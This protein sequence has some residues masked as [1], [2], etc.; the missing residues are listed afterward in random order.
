QR[1]RGRGA[2]EHDPDPAR[3]RDQLQGD[4]D[5][6]PDAAASDP[7]LG[8]RLMR[9]CRAFA[10]LALAVVVLAGCNTLP[11]TEVQQ[12]MTA[13]PAPVPQPAAQPASGSIYAAAN[14]G[15]PYFGYRPLFEDRRPRNVGDI[16]V[17]QINEKTAASKQSDSSVEKS[18]ST[19]F[20]V[21][22]LLGLPGKSFQGANLEAS[23][24]HAF[25]GKGAASSNNDFTG[26]ITVTVI[27][28]LPN[29]NL[30][31]SGEKQIGINHGSEFIRFSGVVNPATIS[32]G[33]AVSST[34]VADARIEYR[35]N[36]QIQS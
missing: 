6:G 29:G 3:L 11:P 4:P 17:I 25:D 7:D 10:V 15:Q 13:R 36:G 2:G 16:L 19:S 34:Q 20:G 21:T 30:L 27:E 33:N 8:A 32:N 23:S 5:L 22:S 31:V 24:D 26:T 28:V 35:A 14:P 12:P 9:S 1:E 18:Q